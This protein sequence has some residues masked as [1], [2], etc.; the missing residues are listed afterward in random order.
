MTNGLDITYNKTAS[1]TSPARFPI[2]TGATFSCRYGYDLQGS[3]SSTC[4]N[5]TDWNP[6]PSSCELSTTQ[7]THFKMLKFLQN[8]EAKCG[9]KIL[10]NFLIK[11]RHTFFDTAHA[12]VSGKN[13]VTYYYVVKDLFQQRVICFSH[14][15]L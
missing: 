9:L 14:A 12:N 7:Y 1:Y 5:S 8:K 6:P 3:E 11:L 15:I 2:G 4:L 13:I 10:D